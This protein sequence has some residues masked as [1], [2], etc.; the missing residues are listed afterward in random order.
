MGG[1]NEA[2]VLENLDVI[3]V[4]VLRQY[5]DE[6]PEKALN[7]GIRVV[8]A[9][10]FFL[11]GVQIIKLIR[12]LVK[13]ALRRGQADSGV[14]HFLDSFLKTVL[15]IVLFFMIASGFGLDATSVAAVLGT[16]GVAIGL[17]V[18]GSLS[19][20]AGGVLLMLLK[21][22]KV[23]DYI[24]EDTHGNEGTVTVIDIFYT[25]LQTADNKVIILP[26]GSLANGSVTNVTACTER[27][28]D[29]VIG[30]SYQ[31]DIARVRAVIT[32]VMAADEAVLK[33][34]EQ[35]VYVDELAEGRVRLGVRCWFTMDDFWEGKWRLT[36]QIKYALDEAGIV[37]PAGAVAVQLVERGE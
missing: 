26:N 37:I 2:E 12:R 34:K 4:G 21:P 23:G 15:Y 5:L 7:M 32:A 16:I 8:M 3:E 30:V 36:E 25:R 6:L 11:I 20:L 35:V 9:L 10:V 31:T 13:K 19:N 22:F 28:F 1:L 24:K 18:Q 27:R 33:D 29:M 17:A 14:G